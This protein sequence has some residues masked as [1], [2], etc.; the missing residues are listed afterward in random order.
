MN[1][2]ASAPDV[3]PN[4]R[5]DKSLP[6]DLA[7]ST[8]QL[9][10][11]YSPPS[12]TSLWAD[13][14]DPEPGPGA[15]EVLSSFGNQPESTKLTG[16][17]SSLTAKHS[18]AWAK[19]LISKHHNSELLCR[20]S[21]GA[22]TYQPKLLKSNA[23][24]KFGGGQRSN[25]AGNV[26]GRSPGPVYEVRSKPEANT[27]TKFGQDD[28]FGNDRPPTLGP[29]QYE[30]LTQF[31]GSRLAKSFGCSF[32]AYRKVKTEG[33]ERELRGRTSTGP[34]VYQENF[35]K[36]LPN[37]TFSGVR[38]FP[39]AER[40]KHRTQA[41]TRVPGPG[42]YDNVKVMEVAKGDC[43]S[44]TIWNQSCRSFGKPSTKPRLD[45]KQ[46]RL[47]SNTTWGMA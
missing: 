36:N 24:V 23:S 47:F 18:K 27:N 5:E 34:G 11:L 13:P 42:A 37:Y 12:Y 8:G 40:M 45:F 14:D 30:A 1:R 43:A 39:R 26:G 15:Y 44:S 32:E 4:S 10:S 9:P 19:V 33:I 46:L 16:F 6:T 22:G 29:G 38:S 25:I 35:G 2:S 41:T 17:S 20:E 28:R 31:D 7:F 3:Q 21:P